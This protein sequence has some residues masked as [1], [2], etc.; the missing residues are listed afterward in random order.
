MTMT[1]INA[2]KQAHEALRPHLPVSPLQQSGSL[3]RTLGCSVLLKNEHLQPTGTNKIRGASIMIR[4]L[5]EE[6]RRKGV[7]TAAGGGRGRA[8]ARAGAGDGGPGAGYV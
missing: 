6:A 7:T 4:F 5:G 1:L 2:I 8:G 3:S